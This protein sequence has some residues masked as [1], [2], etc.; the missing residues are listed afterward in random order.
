[1][2]QLEELRA[3]PSHSGS[4]CW[5]PGIGDKQAVTDYQLTD[6]AHIQVTSA[7]MEKWVDEIVRVLF[8]FTSISTNDGLQR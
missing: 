5:R 1:M 8:V 2:K 6:Y 7:E 4:N 3:C